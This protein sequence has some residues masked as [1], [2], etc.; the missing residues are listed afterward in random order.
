MV[1]LIER[2]AASSFTIYINSKW[3]ID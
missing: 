2:E 1:E 3:R